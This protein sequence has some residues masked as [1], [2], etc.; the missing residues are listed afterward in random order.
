MQ[1]LEPIASAD[2]AALYAIRGDFDGALARYVMTT[3]ESRALCNRPEIMGVDFGATLT[4]A[5]ARSLALLPEREMIVAHPQQRVCVVHFLRGGL[6]F[7]LREALNQAY[8][9]NLHSSCFMSSQRRRVDGRWQVEEDMYRKLRIPADAILMLGDV[10]ATG[11]T[12]ANG[13]GVILDHLQNIGSSVRR[14]VF[15]TIGCHKLEKV[16]AEQERAYRAAFP[17]FEGVSVVYLEG[18]FRLVDDQ[19]ELRIGIPGT[20]LIR[21]DCLLAPEFALSQYD[22]IG[23][24]LERCTIYDAGSRAFD[25]PTHMADVREYWHK[26]E[27]L[28]SAGMTLAEA[29]DERWPEPWRGQRDQFLATMRE[30][31]REVDDA[32]LERMW[33]ASEARSAELVGA[34]ASSAALAAVARRRLGELPVIER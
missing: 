22:D 16:L 15:F 1:F 25:I 7:G 26:V 20:D 13:L 27:G 14:V 29:L 9:F 18:K 10:V 34:A 33:Q 28:A 12:V 30:Q 32:L 19:T 5:V 23:H 8:D 11:I 4:R 6:N 24:P 3:P 31:W 2:Q 21:R 17:A